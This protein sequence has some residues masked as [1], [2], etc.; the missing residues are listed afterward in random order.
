MELTATGVVEAVGGASPEGRGDMIRFVV[1][2]M[3]V[4]GVLAVEK[5]RR[6][7]SIGLGR[8][9]FSVYELLRCYIWEAAGLA[10]C[11][12][13]AAALRSRGDTGVHW[14]SQLPGVDAVAVAETWSTISR[15]WPLLVTG[16]TLLAAQAMLRAVML[17]PF[18][19]RRAQCPGLHRSPLCGMACALMLLGQGC[20]LMCLC[21]SG[22]YRLDGPL[23]G[24]P[25]II[26]E[27]LNTSLLLAIG[28]RPLLYTPRSSGA[29]ALA[30]FAVASRNR[31]S[32]AR[33]PLADTLFPASHIL[34]LLAACVHLVHTVSVGEGLGGACGGAVHLA[35]PLQQSLAAYYYLEAFRAVP[36]VLEVGWPVELLWVGAVTQLGLYLASAAL[37]LAEAFDGIPKSPSLLA[38][39]NS[40]HRDDVARFLPTRG[41]AAPS[42]SASGSCGGHEHLAVAEGSAEV[43]AGR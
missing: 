29:I 34:E 36:E 13:L 27:V 2:T 33:D 24:T 1:G 6:G 4:A 37:H 14:P 35:L 18:I 41:G 30:A 15:E 20:R 3:V 43:L 42:H 8:H 21:Q 40:G 32:L 17:A 12:T 7:S 23:G 25:S 26:L 5:R 39:L 16:D 22:A 9:R 10:V 31:L 11:T 28:L 38:C 19:L